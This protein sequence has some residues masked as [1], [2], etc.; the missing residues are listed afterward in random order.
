MEDGADPNP[1]L[2]SDVPN[3]DTLNHDQKWEA[4]HKTI[5]NL[6]V[7]QGWTKEEILKF[8]RENTGFKAE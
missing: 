7:T 1:Q 6:Y 5:E 2:K 8:L 4:L 3:L